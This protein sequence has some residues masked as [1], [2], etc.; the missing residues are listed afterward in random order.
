MLAVY[1]V[2]VGKTCVYG[3]NVGKSF[4]ENPSHFRENPSHVPEHLVIF[5]KLCFPPRNA[6]ESTFAKRFEEG[7]WGAYAPWVFHGGL[8]GQCP[9]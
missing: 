9:T 6:L 3:V 1:A 5:I 8:E 2:S 7:V 4:R